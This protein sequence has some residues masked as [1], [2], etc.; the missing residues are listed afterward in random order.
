M[1]NSLDKGL[2]KPEVSSE[3]MHTFCTGAVRSTDADNTR[4]DLLSPIAIR[5][6][7]AAMAEGAE[8]YG[9]HNWEKG[10]PI[11]DLINHGL[12]HIFLYLSGDK[13]EDH[14]GHAL[15]N[16]AAAC[17]SEEAWPE[18]NKEVTLKEKTD[19][20]DFSMPVEKE[21]KDDSPLPQP[22]WMIRNAVNKSVNS[23]FYELF[24]RAEHPH[25]NSIWVYRS[26]FF[27]K[28]KAI[29]QC[30]LLNEDNVKPTI[31]NS[32]FISVIEWV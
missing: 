24:H 29:S 11:N 27:D 30:R 1:H 4:Y 2:P 12:R 7:A 13:S 21:E 8:K 31:E 14:L 9:D 23:G 16:V 32:N 19:N 10:M 18:L 17:H 15:W 22:W 28:L 3:E 5:R 20:L 6:Y 26:T 25:K